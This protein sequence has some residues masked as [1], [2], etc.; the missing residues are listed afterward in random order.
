MALAATHRTLYSAAG[1]L[2]IA[3][4]KTCGDFGADRLKHICIKT[5]AKGKWLTSAM[6]TQISPHNPCHGASIGIVNA[7]V[8]SVAAKAPQSP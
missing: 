6:A 8:N 1:G 5:D 4:R 2:L 7:R 3:R